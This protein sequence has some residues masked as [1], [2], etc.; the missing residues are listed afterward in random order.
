MELISVSA[1]WFTGLLDVDVPISLCARMES[2]YNSF[3]NSIQLI[4]VISS[5]LLTL[6]FLDSK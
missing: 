5:K 6:Y 4:E 3:S 2:I 1:D